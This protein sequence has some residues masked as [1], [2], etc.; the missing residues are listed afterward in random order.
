MVINLNF[1]FLTT[2]SICLNREYEDLA[3]HFEEEHFLCQE[4]DCLHEK[5]TH[6]FRTEID[7]KGTFLS[8]GDFVWEP[9]CLFYVLLIAHRAEKHSG[10][11]NSKADARQN[12]VVDLEFNYSRP[13]ARDQTSRRRGR[14]AG[15]S[16]NLNVVD[17]IDG[18]IRDGNYDGE[19]GRAER[20]PDMSDASFPSLGLAAAAS[21]VAPADSL[22]RRLAPSSGYATN[23]S[24]GRRLP[25]EEDFP[26]LPGA[27]SPV[28]R[29]ANVA[30][31]GAKRKQQQ[32]QQ[33]QQ[34][35]PKTREEEF[36][37]LGG[38]AR[39]IP[40]F[41]ANSRPLHRDLPGRPQT[42]T[43]AAASTGNVVGAVVPNSEAPKKNSSNGLN[44]VTLK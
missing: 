38:P 7:L 42:W 4:G 16:S 44:M 26:S 5:F 11:F 43:A 14:D 41:A 31:G 28:H 32:P 23:W 2:L 17:Q 39:N 40:S 9:S 20:A 21:S 1:F 6:A 8:F 37:S 19:G 10:A 33:Q 18:V 13:T 3:K 12:R 29:A 34:Q 36:P 30:A 22:A 15:P 35:K 27:P 24:D 25:K